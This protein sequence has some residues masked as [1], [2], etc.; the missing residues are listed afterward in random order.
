MEKQ[1]RE[2]KQ[3]AM[4]GLSITFFIYHSDVP[5]DFNNILMKP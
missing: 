5:H 3:I 1:S 2:T 4:Y